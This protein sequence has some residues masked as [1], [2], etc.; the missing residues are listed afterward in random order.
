MDRR[1]ALE[2]RHDNA[3]SECLDMNNNIQN[4]QDKTVRSPNAETLEAMRQV[5]ERDRLTE[6]ASLEELMV[7]FGELRPG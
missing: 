1:L 5:R 6:Y 2:R 3:S 7:E 4:G